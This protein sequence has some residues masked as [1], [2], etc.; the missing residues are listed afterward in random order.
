MEVVS[1]WRGVAW[2][3]ALDGRAEHA[4][5][6]TPSKTSSPAPPSRHRSRHQ[7]HATTS[8]SPATHDNPWLG[9]PCCACKLQFKKN[10]SIGLKTSQR[11]VPLLKVASAQWAPSNSPLRNAS[12]AGRRHAVRDPRRLF[13]QEILAPGKI[14]APGRPRMG[15][16]ENWRWRP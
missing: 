12:K 15:G 9:R 14:L 7:L 1:G 5:P 3:K 2:I 11:A 10:V 8:V 6:A 4:E 16:V 13:T